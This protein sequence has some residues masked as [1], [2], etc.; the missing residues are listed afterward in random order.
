MK[1]LVK[2]AGSSAAAVTTLRTPCRCLCQAASQVRRQ[3]PCLQTAQDTSESE[4]AGTLDPPR[5]TSH[6]TGGEA[7]PLSISSTFSACELTER[8]TILTRLFLQQGV[9]KSANEL[10]KQDSAGIFVCF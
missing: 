6:S 4:S 3:S 7:G 1:T 2:A 9:G 10:G 5:G 8:H